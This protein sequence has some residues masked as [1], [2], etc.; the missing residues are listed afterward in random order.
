MVQSCQTSMQHAHID[1]KRST[2]DLAVAAAQQEVWQTEQKSLHTHTHKSLNFSIL[3]FN[4]HAQIE[5]CNQS[6]SHCTYL[7]QSVQICNIAVPPCTMH[8]F[9]VG[10]NLIYLSSNSGSSSP[11]CWKR[12]CRSVTSTLWCPSTSLSGATLRFR[13]WSLF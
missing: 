2:P 11:A 4:P 5:Q 12:H 13:M 1:I 3:I 10:L 6:K 7:P 8:P 9:S